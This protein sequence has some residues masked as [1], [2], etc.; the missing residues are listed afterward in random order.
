MN[1]KDKT[2]KANAPKWWG[3][4]AT[5]SITRD[6]EDATAQL[7]IKNNFD[8]KKVKKEDVQFADLRRILSIMNK[9]YGTIRVD[10]FT[11]SDHVCFKGMYQ[12]FNRLRSNPAKLMLLIKDK[13]VDESQSEDESDDKGLNENVKSEVEECNALKLDRSKDSPEVE[14]PGASPEV[15]HQE[16]KSENG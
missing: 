4:A 7:Y 6:V 16:Q 13:D 11:T 14:K 5:V 12:T 10:D 15:E 8:P 1:K 9:R 3:R 2:D